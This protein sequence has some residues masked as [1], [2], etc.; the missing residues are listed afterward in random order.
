MLVDGDSLHVLL[1]GAAVDGELVNLC[2]SLPAQGVE[3]AAKIKVTVKWAPTNPSISTNLAPHL[4]LAASAV[5]QPAGGGPLHNA[6]Q[7]GNKAM[8]TMLLNFGVHVDST[9]K[10]VGRLIQRGPS[11]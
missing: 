10:D 2:A 3:P 1:S 9:D 8:V 7:A 4:Q 11:C 5:S 6:A